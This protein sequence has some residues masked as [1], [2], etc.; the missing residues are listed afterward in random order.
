VSAFA[1]VFVF[2]FLFSMKVSQT[3]FLEMGGNPFVLY[4]WFYLQFNPFF[5]VSINNILAPS[6]P[7]KYEKHR[8]GGWPLKYATTKSAWLK[9]FRFCRFPVVSAGFSRVQV[10]LWVA[11]SGCNNNHS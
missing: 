9:V 8:V 4:L 7:E 11:S 2:S 5:L 10:F 1:I 6:S 3:G